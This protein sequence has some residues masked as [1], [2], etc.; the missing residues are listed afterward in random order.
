MYPE[1]LVLMAPTV[2][3]ATWKAR[4]G[5]LWFKGSQGEKVYEIPGQS[6]AGHT[7]LHSYTRKYK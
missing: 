1:A 4:S 7:Y 5:G 3:L 6:M 2:T